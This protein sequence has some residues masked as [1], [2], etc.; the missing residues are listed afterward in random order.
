MTLKLR[1]LLLGTLLA[2]STTG[3]TLVIGMTNAEA[4]ASVTGTV[5]TSSGALNLRTGPSTSTAAAGQVGNGTRLSIVCWVSGQSVA[6]A[7]RTTNQWTK[8]TD[9]R[10]VSFAYVQP[11]GTVP[12]CSALAAAAGF[13]VRTDGSTLNV[14][15]APASSAAKTGTV[16]NNAKVNLACAVNGETVRGTVRSTAQWDKL[17]SGGYVSHAY[18]QSSSTLTA[19]AAPTAP[20]APVTYAG[21]AQTTGGPLNVRSAPSSGASLVGAVANGG[22]LTLSCAVAGEYVNGAVRATSQWD[23]LT[24]GN[25]V[26]HG[27][28]QTSATLPACTG[29]TPVGTTGPVASM[30]NA[31]FIAAAVA[32]AQQGYREFR[33]PASVTIA[34][35]IL[36]SGWG[37]SGLTR[38]DRNYFGIKCFNGSPGPIANGCHTYATYECEPTCLPT[39]ASFRTYASITDSFR[40][41]GRF[42]TTNSRYKPAFS[43]SDNADQFLYQMWKA[44]YATSPTYVDNVKSLMRQ[45]NLYQ[46]DRI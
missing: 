33:V 14:R 26:S 46:Y 44:G 45:Y 27:Y 1:Q 28:V 21:T 5:R 29:G 8:L 16:A 40:D 3:S 19:C 38:N 36:E 7:V 4:A 31:Q 9:G 24:S 43:Y 35:S 37:R 34:Q 2:A 25:Y 41:H 12:S 20:A 23:R 22:G 30:T 11:A 32:P 13:T 39:Y 10:Y 15:S 6:G 42:L 17:T 18:I